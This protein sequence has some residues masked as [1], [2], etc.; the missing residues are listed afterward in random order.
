[1]INFII[2]EDD[3]GFLNQLKS[4][5]DLIMLES[6]I[7]YKIYC[8]NNY[9]D[10]FNS[11]TKASI[12]NIIYIL[13]AK[14]DNC[15]NT[16]KELRKFDLKSLIVLVNGATFINSIFKYQLLIISIINRFDNWKIEIKNVIELLKV[17]IELNKKI[18]V[19]KD[20]SIF[21]YEI[22][23]IEYN[24]SRRT[25]IVH[26]NNDIYELRVSLHQLLKTLPK[27]FK[28]YKKS[29]IVNENKITNFDNKKI[30]P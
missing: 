12:E 28:K 30:A 27:S 29:Y 25:S 2:V 11:L 16:I 20:N 5:I 8:C 15:F 24:S 6:K 4:E 9:S 14:I 1:M 22:E 17:N 3:N 19:N 26:T 7:Q 18:T 23:Y 10:D 13:N 21:F